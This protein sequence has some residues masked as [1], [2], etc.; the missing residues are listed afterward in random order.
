MR[1][2][3][4]NIVPF[5]CLHLGCVGISV[6]LLLDVKV[7]VLIIALIVVIS[8]LSSKVRCVFLFLL[9][10]LVDLGTSL[11]RAFANFFVLE[12]KVPAFALFGLAVEAAARLAFN[13]LAVLMLF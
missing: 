11:F 6:R 4:V 10:A 8:K 12:L 5:S 7:V 2:P 3:S 13:G 1:K 9:D